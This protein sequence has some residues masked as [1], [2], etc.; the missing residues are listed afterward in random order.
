MGTV[1]IDLE[2][3]PHRL[4]DLVEVASR[5]GEVVLTSHG[6]AV[7]KIVPL[8]RSQ[9]TRQPGSARGLVH[10]SEDFD[11]LPDELAEYL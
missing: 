11:A 10:M 6:K 8:H 1:D 2:A 4:K 7:A 5:T 3:A 9:G